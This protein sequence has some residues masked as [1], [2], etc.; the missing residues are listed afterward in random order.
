[1]QIDIRT[2]SVNPVRHTFA[3]IA[4]R[5]GDKPASRY[6]EAMYDLQPTANFHYRPLWQPEF[7]LY[8]ARRTRVTMADWYALKDPRQLYYASYVNS[9]ARQQEVMERNLEFAEKR[10]LIAMLPDEVKHILQVGVVPLRHVE[11]AANMNNAYITGFG[12]GTAITQACMYQTMDR[13]GMAQYLTRLGLLVGG[14]Q[15][16]A[17][18]KTAWLDEPLWQPLRQAVEDLLVRQDWFELFVG[19]NLILDGLLYPLVYQKLDQHLFHHHRIGPAFSL[20]TE[21]MSSWYEDASRWVDAV[22]KT[23]AADNADNPAVLSEFAFS[24]LDRF[25]AALVPLAKLMFGD[26]G[27]EVLAALTAPLEARCNK[28]GLSR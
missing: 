19:Q 16:V 17:A 28:L 14:K 4:R 15:A 26:E 18:A 7:E 25:A 1:M 6:Q 24:W 13:L 20:V 9:R 5:F 22:V 21:F 11:W 3:N 27:D 10:G 8:D 12:F 2:D 23:A